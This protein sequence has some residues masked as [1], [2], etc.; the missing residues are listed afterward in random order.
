MA[1]ENQNTNNNPGL[2]LNQQ[3][4]DLQNLRQGLKDLLDDQGDYNNL[5][6]SSLNDLEK[7]STQYKKIQDRLSSLSKESINIKEINQELYKLKQKESD[8]QKK[9]TQLQ[10]LYGK[11]T[12]S[13]LENAKKRALEDK[14]LYESQGASFDLQKQILSNLQ[15]Q[16]NLEAVKIFTQQKQLDFAKQKTIEGQLALENEKNLAKQL[17]LTGNSAEVLAKKLNIGK[18]AYATMVAEARK[19]LEEQ[20]TLSQLPQQKVLNNPP[21]VKA[22][23]QAQQTTGQAQSQ[24][25]IG[26]AQAQAQQI[27]GQA[28]AQASQTIGQAQA[29]AQQIQAQNQAQQTIGQGQTQQIIAQAQAQAQQ[30]IGQAQVQAQQIQAQNQAQQTIGQAQAQAQQTQAQNQAQQTTTQ[31]QAQAQQIIRRVQAQ[32]QQT[33]GQAQAQ[34]QQTITQAQTQAQQIIAQAQ[35]QA[36]QTIRQAQAQTLIRQTI[37]KAQAQRTTGPDR[38]RT[39]QTISGVQQVRSE[40]GDIND[41]LKESINLLKKVDR[42]Y[43]NIEAR[44]S[45]LDK[46]QINIK[47][48]SNELYKAKQKDYIVSK[49]LA[50]AEKT[51]SADSSNRVSQYLNS[52]KKISELEKRK[53]EYEKLAIATSDIAEKKKIENKIANTDRLLQLNIVTNERQRASLSVQEAQVAALRE[54]DSITKEGVAFGERSLDIE[55]Q[56]A[57][58]LGISGNLVKGL[59]TKLGVGTE[60]YEAMT[61]EA[62]RLTEEDAKRKSLQEQLAAAQKSGN[63]DQVKS[64]NEQLAL[65]SKEKSAFSK[66]TSVLKEGFKAGKAAIKDS[67]SDPLAKGGLVIGAFKLAEAGLDGIGNAAAKA[68]NF[69]AG[70]SEDSGNVVRGLTSGVSDLARK[71]PL[72]GGLIGGLVDGFSALLDLV[73]G[74]DNMIVQTGRQLNLSSEGARNLYRNLAAASQA[75]GDIYTNGKK[76]LESQL[77][78]TQQTGI[79]NTL[80]TEILRTNIKLKDF[81]GLEADTRAR[82]AETAQIT[83]KSAEGTVKSVLS[84]VKGLERA[85]GVSLQYQ[86][87]L[88]EVSNLGGYLGLQFAK[89]PDKLA[90]AFVTTKALGLELKQLDGMASSFLDFESSISKEFEAQLLTGKDINLSKARELFLNNDLAGA[91]AE[92]AK[93]T[94]DA[95]GYSKMNRIQQDSLAEAMGM[96]RDQMADMLKQQ[97]LYSKFGVKNREDLLKQVDSLRKA[98]KEQE[99]INKA[100]GEGAYNDLVRASA[101]EKLALTIE[102]IKQSIVEFIE[103]SGIIE[104]VTAFVDKLSNPDTIKGI[105]GTI[106]DTISTFIKFAGDMLA[107]VIEIGGEIADFFTPFGKTD[108]SEKAKITG[109]KVREGSLEMSERI[110]GTGNYGATTVQDAAAKDKLKSESQSK[111]EDNSMS[112]AGGKENNTKVYNIIIVDPVTGKTIEKQVDQQTY[113]MVRLK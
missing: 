28:Q 70:L 85:T 111:K 108:Y 25:T 64:L 80:N 17:G 77:E 22:Q 79:T 48:I 103:R 102:K 38:E 90:K 9:L 53:F 95:A 68:G 75:S 10:S 18:E 33:T 104:K 23:A 74:V 56:T 98:G 72:V 61:T 47:Q 27:M 81:A 100:G 36:Q 86:Q 24:Q 50:D 62:R 107:D 52:Q 99:A 78:L 88:K 39:R 49:Q 83:G 73:L 69:M 43:E 35:A 16:G 66:K 59:A 93:H 31:T 44:V 7:T 41:I 34:A 65:M 87:V 51:L 89:Y 1:N 6:K 76:L 5:L 45:S 37:G 3:S 91:A 113:E 30:T 71:I 8:E 63:T 14:K 110:K 4:L 20:K 42:S 13:S 11:Q 46:S 94:G 60:A 97:E 12:V 109:A 26:Q 82:I 112:M 40:Q 58:Q 101:Q 84:Q 92:I 21:P 15:E 57:K 105:I 32:A 55:K 2:N 19:L 29:Q 67:L 96:S 54:A 106:R